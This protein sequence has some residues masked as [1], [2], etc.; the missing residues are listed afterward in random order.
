M[1]HMDKQSD[2]TGMPAKKRLNED[3][4]F[5]DKFSAEIPEIELRALARIGAGQLKKYWNNKDEID[6]LLHEAY[7]FDGHYQNLVTKTLSSLGE[8]AANQPYD[9]WDGRTEL[10]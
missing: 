4:F 5:F 2:E 1:N 8:Y 7:V 10:P 9:D 6:R 3:Q